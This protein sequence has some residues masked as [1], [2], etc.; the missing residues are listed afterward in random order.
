MPDLVGLRSTGVVKQNELRPALV[1]YMPPE[2][3]ALS[4]PGVYTFPRKGSESRGSSTPSWKDGHRWR[5]QAR[6][7][8]MA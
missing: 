8:L 2:Y 7:R 6:P 5:N 4:L 3:L 1:D